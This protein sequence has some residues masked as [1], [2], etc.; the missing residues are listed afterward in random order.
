MQLKIWQGIGAVVGLTL[1][2]F[3]GPAQ[4]GENIFC[5]VCDLCAGAVQ[6]T[7]EIDPATCESYC[8]GTAGAACGFM[9]SSKPCAALPD[10]QEAVG[11]PALGTRGLTGLALLLAGAGALG[12]RRAAR[13]KRG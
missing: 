10:C 11:V 9:V 1:L 12:A 3:V 4:A 5:C 13:R 7:M 8:S 6:C 2:A